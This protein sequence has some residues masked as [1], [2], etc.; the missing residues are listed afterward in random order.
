[1]ERKV[2]SP[3]QTTLRASAVR[4]VRSPLK[5]A[6]L[7]LSLL[8][9]AIACSSTSTPAD[10]PTPAP[11]NTPIPIPANTPTP[12]P[13][14]TPIPMPSEPFR[15]GLLNIGVLDFLVNSVPLEYVDGEQ[16]ED[17]G[18]TYKAALLAI[19]HVNDAGGVW[20]KPVE[21]SFADSLPVAVDED[22]LYRQL[23][24]EG[25]HGIVGATSPGLA[26]IGK[27]IKDVRVPIVASFSSAPS[28]ARIDDD[29]FIFRTSISDL[30]QAYALA[31]LVENDGYHYVAVGYVDDNWGR[32][33]LEAFTSHFDGR[34]DAVSLPL[35]PPQPG[36]RQ[37]A[38]DSYDAHL[39]QLAEDDAPALVILTYRVVADQI[40]DE[41]AKD[42]HFEEFLLHSQLRTLDF[43]QTHSGVLENAKGVFSYGLHVTEAEGHW[44]ADYMAEFGLDEPP[45]SPYVRETYDAAVALMLAAEHAKSTNGDAIRDSLHAIAGP[46]G[47]RYPA[48]AQGIKDALQA[49][50]NGE[51]ID[52][53]GEASTLDWDEHGELVTH[54]M[55]VWQFK[56]GAIEDLYHFDVD[57]SK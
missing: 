3:I 29:S 8:A 50:R 48:S 45:H 15:L 38:F 51:E 39:H 54:T 57:L 49:I 56:N 22:K 21:H 40:M 10:T 34:V 47:T 11:A 14:A 44:E 53:D 30:A 25:S 27:V 28:V 37:E 26:D 32:E 43:Y 36:E 13:T 23:V 18:P 35:S 31:Q 9:A 16:I 17:S 33:M 41:V 4:C 24:G 1:M 20:G 12:V 7:S 19:E 6:L 46:P 55:G 2:M 5:S 52:L 42:N